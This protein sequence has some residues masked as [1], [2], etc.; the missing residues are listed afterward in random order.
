MPTGRLVIVAPR[1]W[2]RRERLFT[3]RRCPKF[4]AVK[5]RA[6]QPPPT[7]AS[8]L[9][10]GDCGLPTLGPAPKARC[11]ACSWRLLA[12]ALRGW[13]SPRAL[14]PARPVLVSLRGMELERPGLASLLDTVSA[15]PASGLPQ[16]SA[17]V[18]RESA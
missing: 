15:H 10:A 17:P 14:E 7:R 1:P 18:R 2:R 5:R 3:K 8:W 9:R 16:A 6:T 11:R 13:V 4:S 12:P